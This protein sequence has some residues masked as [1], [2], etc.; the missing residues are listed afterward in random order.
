MNTLPSP[1]YT[2]PRRFVIGGKDDAAAM[3]HLKEHGFVVFK[4][5][6]N[7]DE[8]SEALDLIWNYLESL[9]TG[10]KR[11]DISTWGNDNWPPSVGGGI[12][13]WFGAGQSAAMWYLRSKPSIKRAFELIWDTKKLLVSFDGVSLFRPWNHPFG[14]T[15]WKTKGSWYHVYF[16]CCTFNH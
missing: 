9:G 8:C 15:K 4:D 1:E 11:D 12:L 5:V 7:L 2:Q 6:L 14:D 10:V 13:P 16:L 3:L